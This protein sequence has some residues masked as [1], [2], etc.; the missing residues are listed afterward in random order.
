M[1]NTFKNILESTFKDQDNWNYYS[2]KDFTTHPLHS[3]DESKQFIK[4]FFKLSGKSEVH[5]DKMVSDLGN[6]TQHVVSAFFLGHYI[7]QNTNLK[8]KIDN[9]ITKFKHGLNITSE[10]NF[11]YMWFLIC[12]FHDIGYNIEKQQP[13]RY[14]NIEQLLNETGAMPE[15]CGIPKFYNAIY[16]NYF[17]YRLKE[18]C[19]NDHGITIAHIMYYDLCKI[20]VQAE[21]IPKDEQK[22]LRWEKDLEKIYTFC[23]WNVLAHNIWFAEKS[24]SCDV[25]NYKKYKM[26][27]LIFEEKYKIN[28]DKHPFFFLFC[29]VDTI[30]PYKKV[31]DLEMLEKIDLEIFE[32]KIIITSNIK[33]DCGNSILNQSKGL[34]KWLTFTK[35]KNN[36]FEISLNQKP[37]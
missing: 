22:N 21:N 3:E 1:K 25:R 31:F 35:L 19:K 2:G 4:N 11:S 10:V 13:P 29:L 33:C 16:K 18:H 17:T 27:R 12:L 37:L 14:N 23:S 26:K 8:S 6:R 9:E 5:F 7:Y 34:D 20:R 28:P 36:T 24:K 32:D 15:I 30:E